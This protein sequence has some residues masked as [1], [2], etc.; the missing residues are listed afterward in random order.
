MTGTERADRTRPVIE[1]VAIV[2]AVV[3]L[4]VVVYFLPI[5]YRTFG[6]SAYAGV[7]VLAFV[8]S[9]AFV[10]PIPYLPI[11][12]RIAATV[13]PAWVVVLVAAFGSVL[14][15]STGWYVGRAGKSIVR[16]GKAYRWVR[17]VAGDPV[18]AGLLLCA[19]AIP[20]DPLFDVA[21]LA[22]GALGVRYRTFFISVLIG[23]SLHFAL[24]AIIAI[25]LETVLRSL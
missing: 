25:G 10:L 14:G 9:G 7:F 5:D 17:H 22:A 11:V 13:G 8:A 1:G 2:S 6:G 24:V 20:P 23:R 16:E 12:A 18:L 15:D 19:L 3:I 4:N 21:G